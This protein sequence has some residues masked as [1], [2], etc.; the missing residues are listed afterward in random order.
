MIA[1]PRTLAVA[2]GILL[3][4]VPACT[5]AVFARWGA[6]SPLLHA[7]AGGAQAWPVSCEWIPLDES[8]ALHRCPPTATDLRVT[9]GV[10]R[11][12][13]FEPLT[14][15]ERC[16]GNVL[17]AQFSA[18]WAEDRTLFLVVNPNQSVQAQVALLTDAGSRLGAVSAGDSW[19]HMHA[20]KLC[21]GLAV[22][23]LSRSPD[24]GP[25]EYWEGELQLR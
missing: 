10:H 12:D 4:Y 11:G 21:F 16:G 19:A 9:F 7:A 17:F 20:D 3:A 6:G 25:A 22:E 15:L 5:Y 18:S 24:P 2:I 23:W 14:R 13:R 8:S 1:H